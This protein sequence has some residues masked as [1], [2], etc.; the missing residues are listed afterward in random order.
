MAN[1]E[2]LQALDLTSASIGDEGAEAIFEALK[3]NTTLTELV[4]AE[5]SIT[6]KALKAAVPVLTLQNTTLQHLDLTCTEIGNEG[7][8]LLAGILMINTTLRTVILQDAQIGDEGATELS[9]ALRLN[10]TLELLDLASNQ[11]E[12]FQLADLDRGAEPN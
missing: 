7:A 3:L 9:K 11:F 5:N 8:R 4:L 12:T 2:P 6:S 10:K 1:N